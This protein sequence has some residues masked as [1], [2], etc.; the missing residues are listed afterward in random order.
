MRVR[1]SPLIEVTATFAGILLVHFV[2]GVLANKL[3]TPLLNRYSRLIRPFC[4]EEESMFY[5]RILHVPQW[6]DAMPDLAR[7]LSGGFAKDRIQSREVS[8]LRR[9]E[10]E[11]RF[12]QI[13]HSACFLSLPIFLLRRSGL[14]VLLVAGFLAAHLPCLV[15]QRYNHPRF[16]RVL[17]KI[18]TDRPAENAG[19]TPAIVINKREARSENSRQMKW[20][21]FKK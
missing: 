9:F 20:E 2:I 6:K 3:K 12:S 16:L 5:E 21:I 19:A 10:S 11:I 17:R 4:W 7:R 1:G 13:M 14:R 8:Y 18:S 15:I